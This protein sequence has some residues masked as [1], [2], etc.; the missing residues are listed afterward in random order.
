[1]SKQDLAIVI[2]SDGFF[3]HLSKDVIAEQVLKMKD[4][5]QHAAIT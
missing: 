5:T 2:G 1:M 3:E 4:E